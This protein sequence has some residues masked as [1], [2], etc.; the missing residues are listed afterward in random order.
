VKESSVS[1]ERNC[2]FIEGEERV[3][4][5]NQNDTAW[6]YKQSSDKRRYNA[7]ETD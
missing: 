1:S 6:Q 2:W 4:L 7:H 5:E 3:E